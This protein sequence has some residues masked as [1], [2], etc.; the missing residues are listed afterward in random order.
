MQ[1]AA[2]TVPFLRLENVSV[3][4]GGKAVLHNISFAIH[5]GEQWALTGSSGSGKSMLARTL[6]GRHFHTGTI[7]RNFDGR[8]GTLLM[9]QWHQFRNRSNMTGQFY[10]QQR[11]N[12]FDAEDSGTA[13]ELLSG[14]G[15]RDSQLPGGKTLT[16]VLQIDSLLHKP[17]IQLSNGENK[18]LQLALTLL[19]RPALLIAD[20]PFLGLDVAGR[21]TLQQVLKSLAEE[22]QQMLLICSPQD[23]PPFISHVALLSQGKLIFTGPPEELPAI[24]PDLVFA[25]LP[26]SEDLAQ[27]GPSPI[28]DSHTFIHMEN[29][30]VKYG[31]RIILD[32]INWTVN[33]GE[34]WNI[35]GPNG[36]G[37]STLL[38]LITGDNPQAYANPVYIFGKKRG[39]GESIW[40]I[41]K[42]IGFL[43]PEL[44]LHFNKSQTVLETIASG[45]FDTIGL[46]RRPTEEQWESAAHWTGLLGLEA[47]AYQPLEVLS[48]GLQRIVLLARALVKNPPL[49][50][51]DEPCQG[52]DDE[53]IRHFKILIDRICEKFGTTLLYVSHYSSHIPSCVTNYLYLE[54]GRIS[55]R[56]TAP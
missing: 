39:S 19:H 48:A 4:A 36:A 14:A 13:G 46:F 42:K 7:T 1:S 8:Q 35:S 17:V 43:S 25:N 20:N 12:S 33:R 21:Q 37:K 55:R 52:L 31:D 23:L 26:Y 22:G 47:H 45:W 38:S 49:L 3:R 29:V 28:V 5:K 18:R 24:T 27:L 30:Q 11:Y 16:Q 2:T 32:D 41:K 44:H 56:S 6:A 34:C 10:Y 51:L 40:D 53:Q 50:I 15:Y 54:Q 9:E